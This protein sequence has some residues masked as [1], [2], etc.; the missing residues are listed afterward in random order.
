MVVLNCP[1]VN[2][3]EQ[4]VQEYFCKMIELKIAGYSRKHYFGVL[5]IAQTDFLANHL[6]VCRR[7]RDGRSTVLSGAKSLPY[8]FSKFFKTE[9]S[10]EVI[11]RRSN[12]PRHLEAVQQAMKECLERGNRISYYSSWTQ[13]PLIRNDYET[14]ALIKELFAAMTVHHHLEEGITDLLGL[15]LPKFNTD[16]FFMNWGFERALLQ[17]QP[18]E[19]VPLDFLAGIDCVLMHLMHYSDYALEMSEKYKGMWE[20]RVVVGQRFNP[21]ELEKEIKKAA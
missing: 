14:V 15:G 4:T 10:A 11:F 19:N 2:W 6:L 8:D 17:R 3:K 5:P 21:E 7:E 12:Q 20:K 16:R 9:F 18:V 1:Y 13:N